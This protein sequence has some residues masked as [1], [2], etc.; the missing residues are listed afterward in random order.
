MKRQ[1]VPEWDRITDYRPPVFE[2]YEFD[3]KMHE[4]SE[5][6]DPKSSRGIDIASLN[7]ARE[8]VG[9]P[10]NDKWLERRKLSDAFKMGIEFAK[11]HLNGG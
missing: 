11:R 4:E 3:F 1:E 5:P 2:E 9:D 6:F 10:H 8:I 7:Y